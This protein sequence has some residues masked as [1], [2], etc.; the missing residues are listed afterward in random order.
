M[1]TVSLCMIARDEEATLERV[2]RAMR[3][4]ADEIIV[5]DTGSSDRTV[6]I[7]EQSLRFCPKSSS[8]GI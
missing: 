8:Q 6:E 1:A 3:E 5:A 4:A 2:L 7:A